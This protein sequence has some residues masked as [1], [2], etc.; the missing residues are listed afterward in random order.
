MSSTPPLY[1]SNMDEGAT[2]RLDDPNF[3]PIEER[4]KQL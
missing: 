2:W 4:P 3:H 1:P